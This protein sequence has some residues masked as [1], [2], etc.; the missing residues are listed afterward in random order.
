M[1]CYIKF[2]NN[3]NN[4]FFLYIKIF[5]SLNSSEAGALCRDIHVCTVSEV[6]G[7]VMLLALS[8]I[9]LI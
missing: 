4:F 9:T 3:N 7:I 8:V 1:G 5:V 2:G 6:I